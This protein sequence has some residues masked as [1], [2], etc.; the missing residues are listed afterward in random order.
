MVKFVPFSF[1]MREFMFT[2]AIVMLT[3]LFFSVWLAMVAV[4]T[5]A[6]E[7]VQDEENLDE[8]AVDFFAVPED[9]FVPPE[10]LAIYL[11]LPFISSRARAR[12]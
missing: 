9:F 10:E 8:E 12:A 7:V 3:R 2:F 4:G 1:A 5:C 6:Q 11:S